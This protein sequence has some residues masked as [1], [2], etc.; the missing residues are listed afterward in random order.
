M[1]SGRGGFPTRPAVF[2]D[3]FLKIEIFEIL[4]ELHL[5]FEICTS[6]E[7]KTYRGKVSG[8]RDVCVEAAG[9]KCLLQLGNAI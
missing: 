5:N 7:M 2:D 4:L 9:L 3:L 1:A 6:K 8:Y